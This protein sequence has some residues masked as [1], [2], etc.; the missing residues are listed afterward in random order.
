MSDRLLTI[1]VD[2]ALAKISAG[3]LRS[4]NEVA[5]ALVR[6]AAAGRPKTVGVNLRR[7]RLELDHDGQAP[8]AQVIGW[9]KT[10][11]ETAN[12]ESERHRALKGLEQA[13]CLD[14][15]VG[16]AVKARMVILRTGPPTCL[17][18][19]VRSGTV[20]L[21]E[22]REARHTSLLL[23]GFQG[24]V[25]E[26]ER[27]LERHLRYADFQVSCNGRR[28]DR[29]LALED[30]VLTERFSRNGYE[31]LVGLPRTGQ[32]ARTR[33]VN[34]GV[35][36]KDVWDS[37]PSGAVWDA[38]VRC[39]AGVEGQSR[40]LSLVSEQVAGLYRKLAGK[41][42]S[43]GSEDRLR[44]VQLLFRLA[45]NGAG[46]AAVTDVPVFAT[47]AGDL[48]TATDLS[49][50]AIG[51]IVRAIGPGAKAERYELSGHIFRLDDRRR[52][53]VERHL[54][55]LV[56]EPPRRPTPRS[57]LRGWIT[58]SWRSGV[59]SLRQALGRLAAARTIP[60][61]QLAAPEAA[62]RASLERA[63]DA[64]LLPG[65][66]GTRV[67]FVPSKLFG[68]RWLDLG[69]RGQRLLLGRKHRQVGFMVESCL[70]R[71]ANIYPAILVLTDGRDAFGG[72]RQRAAAQLAGLT[73]PDSSPTLPD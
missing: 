40:A 25:A 29:A 64:G 14:L 36:S 57:R 17:R 8:S 5:L 52:D 35:L 43:L 34:Y 46:A 72:R 1:D 61:D 73:P 54:G 70:G 55:L 16:F 15:L 63:L 50:T 6:A 12:D 27:E 51:R 33:L 69:S 4:Q 58:R 11:L 42:A 19:I 13:A 60:E 32:V 39:P 49:S 26:W 30:S 2:A 3:R 41:Y 68:W 45:D 37:P 59:S 9:L 53:F 71:P 24:V 7:A 65:R 62:F 31:G 10:L 48:C 20:Q 56:R 44:I 67:E 18:L 23:I 66:K 38:V 28:L 22:D 47:L 21:N